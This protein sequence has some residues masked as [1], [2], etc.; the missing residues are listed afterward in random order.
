MS[1]NNLW[2]SFD[3]VCSALQDKYLSS[4]SHLPG[5]DSTIVCY[6]VFYIYLLLVYFSAFSS[7]I[8]CRLIKKFFFK[9]F[10]PLLH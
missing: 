2:Q 3:N 6:F 8:G 4:L 7:L 10:S 1:E 5:P 9:S